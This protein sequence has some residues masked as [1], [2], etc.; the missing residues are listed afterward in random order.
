MPESDAK[1]IVRRFFDEAWNQKK[2]AELEQY[3]SANNVHRGLSANGPYGPD[4]I[5]QVMRN[6]HTAF[7]DFRYHIEAMIAE[8][9]VVAVRT[10]F[11][12]THSGTFSFES[13]N[14][15]PSGKS[16]RVAEMFFFRVADGKVIESSATWDRLSVLA[17]LDAA[18]SQ[19]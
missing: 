13:R 18:P 12:G 6:W 11:T 17:Q 14:L 7:P 3:I 2:V 8:D 1:A 9:D 5:R 4:H 10:T 19:E 16:L 15:P